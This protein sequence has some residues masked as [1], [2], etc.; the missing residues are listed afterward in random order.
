M[1]TFGIAVERHRTLNTCHGVVHSNA[2]DGM[3]EDEILGYL[4]PQKVLSVHRVMIK[5]DE[6]LTPSRTLSHLTA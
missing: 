1:L 4:E 5:R 6:I 3:A 2:F